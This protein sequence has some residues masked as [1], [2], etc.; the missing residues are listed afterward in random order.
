MIFYF[1][2]LIYFY[3]KIMN[4]FHKF[5]FSFQCFFYCW[6]WLIFI[7]HCDIC[8]VKLLPNAYSWTQRWENVIFCITFKHYLVARRKKL[9]ASLLHLFDMCKD[10]LSFSIVFCVQ[11]T[12]FCKRVQKIVKFWCMGTS[13]YFFMEFLLKLL[14]CIA[15]LANK[16]KYGLTHYDSDDFTKKLAM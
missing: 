9:Q 1:F 15:K 11:K 13:F 14:V 8:I 7:D 6:I 5:Y 2:Y 4:I 10:Q 16:I 3:Q 12:F